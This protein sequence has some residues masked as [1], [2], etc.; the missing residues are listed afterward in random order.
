MKTKILTILAASLIAFGCA[1]V[2]AEVLFEDNFDSYE[3]LP[4]SM[5]SWG[6]AGL[7]DAA[8]DLWQSPFPAD[9][10]SDAKVGPGSPGLVYW[11]GNNAGDTSLRL[12]KGIIDGFWGS[13]YTVSVDCYKLTDRNTDDTNSNGWPDYEEYVPEFYV[14]GRIDGDNYVIGGVVLADNTDDETGDSNYD[15]SYNYIGDDFCKD[16]IYIRTRD[17]QGA[18]NGDTYLC[19]LDASKP[20]HISMNMVGESVSLTVSHNGYEATVFLTTEVLNNGQAG[21]GVWR[22]WGGYAKAY[23]DNF[24]VNGDPYYPGLVGD[25]NG[26]LIVDITDLAILAQNWAKCSDPADPACDQYWK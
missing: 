22:R 14:G 2:Q 13:D 3:T 8:P 26:D 19:K 11:S 10:G 21:F 9:Y 15:S 24:A 17:S 25:V 4:E 18:S 6:F 12:Y 20:V 5:L 7:A 16:E 23:Y 1:N